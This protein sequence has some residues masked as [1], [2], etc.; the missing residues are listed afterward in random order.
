MLPEI[1]DYSFLLESLVTSKPDG[2]DRLDII[3][4]CGNSMRSFWPVV[5]IG[6]KS[7]Q[8]PDMR[9]VKNERY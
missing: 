5:K 1:V 6:E 3:V 4:P 2:K 9:E 8:G 7:Y